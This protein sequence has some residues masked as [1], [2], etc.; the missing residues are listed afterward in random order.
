MSKFYGTLTNE[1]GKATKSGH[2]YIRATAQNYGGSVQVILAPH[3]GE[4]WVEIYVSDISEDNPAKRIL[5]MPL[6]DFI[7]LGVDGLNSALAD[8]KE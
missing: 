3:K 8:K 1:K 4:I 2:K 7:V 5:S 6:G